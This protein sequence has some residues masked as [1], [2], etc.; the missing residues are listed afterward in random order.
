[1]P[2]SPPVDT[3]AD[4]LTLMS[5]SELYLLKKIDEAG[6]N[7]YS[8]WALALTEQGLQYF[9]D[10]Q[11]LV[12]KAIEVYIW[13]NLNQKATELTDRNINANINNYNELTLRGMMFFERG[14]YNE[15]KKY[16]SKAWELKSEDFEIF[17]SLSYSLWKT[18]DQQKAEEILTQAAETNLDNAENLAAITYAFLRIEKYEKAKYYL[19]RLKQLA[20]NHPRVQKISGKIAESNGDSMGA[21]SMYESS[22]KGN[23]KD[24][25]TINSLGNLLID[26]KLWVRFYQF[27]NEVISQNPNNPVF[28]EKWG[29][30]YMACPDKSLR[31]LD[32]AIEYLNRAF[33]HISSPPHIVLSAGKNLSVALL[34]KR[35]KENALKAVNKTINYAQR[36]N[37]P[38]NVKE[39]LEKLRLD[40]QNL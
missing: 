20:P 30:F 8:N 27:Y 40:I 39:E 22:F 26:K 4:Q 15:A 11:N 35:D 33:I 12:S 19:N 7:A 31:N 28:L 14:M 21:I 36:N 9:P 16:L 10:N 17:I 34:I 32:E 29:T 18:G 38:Q 1:V 2:F 3:L 6:N 23:P 13:K 24:V 5:R 25:E 37:A